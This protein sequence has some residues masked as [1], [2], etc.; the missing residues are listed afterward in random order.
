MADIKSLEDRSKNMAAIKNKN[1]KPEIYLRKEL[2]SRGYRYR[3]AS[4]MVPG[5]PDMYLAKY[6]LAIFVHGCFWHR[7][8]G[9]KYSYMPKSR[10]DFW[11][12]KFK[13]NIVRDK[14]V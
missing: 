2:F 1:T 6:K 10:V 14:T 3:I 9:C 5:H 13:S 12:K 8:E 4:P 7:H 11:D